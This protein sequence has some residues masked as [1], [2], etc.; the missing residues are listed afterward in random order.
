VRKVGLLDVKKK[1]G[2][3]KTRRQTQLGGLEDWKGIKKKKK[4]KKEKKKKK[5]K[6]NT[7]K[8]KKKTKKMDKGVWRLPRVE[9]RDDLHERL[10]GPPQ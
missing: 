8:K 9:G 3:P 5:K 1:G 4:K 2:V 6:K 7:K 10:S